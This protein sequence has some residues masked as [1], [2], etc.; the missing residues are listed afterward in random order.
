MCEKFRSRFTRPE[1]KTYPNVKKLKKA[2]CEKVKVTDFLPEFVSKIQQTGW[3]SI[4][5]GQ[6]AC[7]VSDKL[8]IFRCKKR[9]RL[10][11]APLGR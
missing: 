8:E 5:D 7:Y 9:H 6:F 3:I 11:L 1:K 10:G 2:L 4:I